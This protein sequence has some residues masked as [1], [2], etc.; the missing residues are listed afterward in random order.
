MSKAKV[1]VVSPTK[2][3]KTSNT[4]DTRRSYNFIH[5]GL[6]HILLEN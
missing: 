5:L 1:T 2:W 6:E 3:E 4:N